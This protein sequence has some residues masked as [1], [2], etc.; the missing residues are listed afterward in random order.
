MIDMYRT[1][2]KAAKE[3]KDGPL[4]GGF[5]IVRDLFYKQHKDQKK[6][7]PIPRKTP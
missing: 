1:A 6:K 7:K 3:K 2:V 4:S 5:S